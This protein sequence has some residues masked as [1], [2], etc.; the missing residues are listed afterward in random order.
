[1]R[2]LRYP[3]ICFFLNASLLVVPVP[4]V[5][6]CL[7]RNSHFG[8]DPYPRIRAGTSDYWIRSGSDLFLH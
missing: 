3:E 8:A 2:Q 6:N 7:Q 1:M 5:L 4:T